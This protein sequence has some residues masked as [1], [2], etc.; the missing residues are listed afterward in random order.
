VGGRSRGR[1]WLLCSHG[2]PVERMVHD[3]L[4][5]D[6]LR[7]SAYL[8]TG[9]RAASPDEQEVQDGEGEEAA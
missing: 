5:G 6:L 2:L 8:K 1:D 9:M 3:L 4:H 7:V